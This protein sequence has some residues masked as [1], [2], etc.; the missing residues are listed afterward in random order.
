MPVL[1]RRKKT[2]SPAAAKGLAFAKPTREGREASDREERLARHLRMGQIRCDVI[3]RLDEHNLGRCENPDCDHE[4]R[5]WGFVADH[6]L[7]GSGRRQ[8]EERV[9]TVWGLCVPCN[10]ARTANQP[11]AA[12][13]NDRHRR[14]CERYGYKF[15]PHHTPL[16]V[17]RELATSGTL[18]GRSRAS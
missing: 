18:D 10:T 17:M 14:H 8:A 11:S 3:A 15:T 16:D 2:R 12:I 7:G 5:I 13:W 4:V 1:R 6:W 9:E